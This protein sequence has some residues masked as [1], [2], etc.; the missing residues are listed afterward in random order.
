MQRYLCRVRRSLLQGGRQIPVVIQA[1]DMSPRS[2]KDKIDQALVARWQADPQTAVSAIVRT[3]GAAEAHRAEVEAAG[4]AVRR[5]FHLL[6]GL[7]VGGK[8][9]DVLA[10]ADCPWVKSVSLDREVHTMLT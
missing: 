5:I 10:L 8:M 6:P 1:A 7:A 4:L 9:S 3:V 2:G